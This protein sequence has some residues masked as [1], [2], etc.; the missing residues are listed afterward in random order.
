MIELESEYEYNSQTISIINKQHY[1]NYE[2][3]KSK[4]STDNIVRINHPYIKEEI[5]VPCL[6]S[7]R[8]KQ[9]IF[10]LS[11][12]K[13]KNYE[14]EKSKKDLKEYEKNIVC[15]RFPKE[16]YCGCSIPCSII[17]PHVG[18]IEVI[19]DKIYAGPIESVYKTKDLMCQGITHI[20]NLSCME[21]H[22]RRFFKYYDIFIND[23]HTENAIK[24]FKITNRFIN[25]ALNEE[26]FNNNNK[27]LIHSVQGK[28]RC[29][30]FII[31]YLIGREEQKFHQAVE[32]VKSKFPKIE[33]N[34]NF[35]TQLKHYD[36]ETNC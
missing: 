30:V 4:L 20:L 5:V 28:G 16:S 21:Y 19:K 9:I 33:I 1:S 36:L 3:S 18:I 13:L 23:T 14:D 35:Y 2:T 25:N 7:E 31:A 11:N 34:D 27:V 22:K 6:D 15:G 29:W 8:E 32:I 17:V 26:N 12:F 24:F 10:N